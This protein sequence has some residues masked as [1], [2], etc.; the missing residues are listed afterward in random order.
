MVKFGAGK[1]STSSRQLS[2][3]G[4]IKIAAAMGLLAGCRAA[5]LRETPTPIPSPTPESTE[6]PA[7]TPTVPQGRP[8]VIQTYPDVTSRVVHTHHAGAWSG[9][10]LEPNAL[11]QMLDASI[12]EL[13]GLH[14][15]GQAWRTLFRPGERVAIKVNAFHNSRIWTHPALV[16]AI[17]DALQEAGIAADQIVIFD[18][19]TSELEEAGYPV[20]PDGAGVRCYGTDGDYVGDY[21]VVSDVVGRTTQLSRILMDAHALINVPIFKA[22]N[23]A[24]LTL[25]MKNNYGSIPNPESYHNGRAMSQGM[26]AL[27]ALAPI[28]ERTRLIVGDLLCGC[29]H[30][31]RSYPYWEADYEGDSIL[32]SFDPVAHDTVGLDVLS[33]LLEGGT[34]WV[35]RATPWLEQGAEIGLGAHD[36]GDFEL[37]ELNLG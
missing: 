18:C 15:A 10:R 32:M 19:R 25:A 21:D 11:R 29:L 35:T 3:R 37:A 14:D 34:G 17:V 30:P 4:F 22:H 12:T 5:G 26:P 33:E 36:P 24:G 20:N 23:I 8:E 2:R 9:E 1:S 7:P 31:A 27:N 13:T 28:Q 6:T 16:M